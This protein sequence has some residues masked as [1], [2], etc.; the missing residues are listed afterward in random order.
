RRGPSYVVGK[1]PVSVAVADFNS[2]ARLDL[3][4]AN[5]GTYPGFTDGSVSILL[6]NGDG[7][8]QHAQ[9]YAAGHQPT[10]VA[11]GYL[12]GDPFPDLA[13]TVAAGVSVLLSNGDGTF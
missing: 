2:D 1:G 11:A 5:S 6:G 4:V 10:S 3:A 8:F 12:K 9:S 7:T 13:V